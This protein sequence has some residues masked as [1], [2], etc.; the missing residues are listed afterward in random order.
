MARCSC[1]NCGQHIEFDNSMVGSEVAC[2]SCGMDTEL[3]IPGGEAQPEI[4]AP[5]PPYQQVDPASAAT[6]TDQL[7]SDGGMPATAEGQPMPQRPGKV[8]AIS[9]MTLAGGIIAILGC[10][11]ILYIT[12]FLLAT[13]NILFFL[14]IISAIYSIILGILATIKGSL[15]LA[16]KPGFLSV[17]TIAIMQIINLISCPG[18]VFNLPLGIITLVFLKDPEVKNYLRSKRL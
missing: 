1:N 13:N 6:T 5:T 8:L 4:E 17:K 18:F 11:F 15:M 10:G 12:A 14:T 9:I 16:N 2:P 3:F 7:Q